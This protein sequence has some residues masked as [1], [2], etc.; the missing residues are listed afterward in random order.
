MKIRPSKSRSLDIV[1]SLRSHRDLTQPS[2]TRLLLNLEE[3]L[4]NLNQFSYQ[5]YDDFI[6][7]TQR[8]CLYILLFLRN[9]RNIRNEMSEKWSFNG[10]RE[11]HYLKS[12]NVLPNLLFGQKIYRLCRILPWEVDFGQKRIRRNSFD[13]FSFILFPCNINYFLEIISLRIDFV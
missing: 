5:F 4:D 1:K 6:K 12:Q 11:I 13:S 7:Y 2:Y 9:E 8:I 3:T 10:F